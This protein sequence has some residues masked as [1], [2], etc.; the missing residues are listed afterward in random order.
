MIQECPPNK[1]PFLPLIYLGPEALQA[2]YP[3][4]VEM[5]EQDMEGGEVL[6]QM[7]NFSNAVRATLQHYNIYVD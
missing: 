7:V 4:T 1:P 2:L 5:I 6:A 3:K